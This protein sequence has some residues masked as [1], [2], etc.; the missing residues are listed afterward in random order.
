MSHA[1]VYLQS[2]GD[3]KLYSIW[4]YIKLIKDGPWEISSLPRYMPMSKGAALVS[5]YWDGGITF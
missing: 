4:L 5:R 2:V 1:D 3:Q